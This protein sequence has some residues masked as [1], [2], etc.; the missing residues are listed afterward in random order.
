MT[1][2]PI[3]FSGEMVRALLARRK[4]QTRRVIA[5]RY[6]LGGPPE[7]VLLASCPYGVAGDRL[8]VKET[9]FHVTPW[10]NVPLFAAVKGDFIYRAEYEYREERGSVIGCHHWR[11]SIFMTRAASRIAL[12]IERVRAERVQDISEA[13]AIAEGVRMIDDSGAPGDRHA[14][15]P[16]W[17]SYRQEYRLLWNRINLKPKPLFAT[18]P[19]GDAEDG[20]G[21]SKGVIGYT[22]KPWSEEDFDAEYPGVR[23]AGVYRGKPIT[24]TA[25][26]WVWAITFKQVG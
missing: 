13:D 9:F 12:N 16:A 24:I 11:P 5:D 7:E 4:T 10:R 15:P 26:P 18:D 3:L 17:W 14:V 22:S 20:V 2:R 19:D 23:A 21:T 6:L 1:A 8:W 25:N